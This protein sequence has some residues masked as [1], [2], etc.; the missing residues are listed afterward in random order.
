MLLRLQMGAF[1]AAPPAPEYNYM[2]G[3]LTLPFSLPENNYFAK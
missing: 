3:F 2:S 1:I